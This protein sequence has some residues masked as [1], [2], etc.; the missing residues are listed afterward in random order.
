MKTKN[1]DFVFIKVKKDTDDYLN[2]LLEKTIFTSKSELIRHG[3]I[4]VQKEIQEG[5]L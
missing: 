2:E 1:K 3:L 4:L 5:R